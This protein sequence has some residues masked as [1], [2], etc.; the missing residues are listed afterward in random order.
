MMK[1]LYV[2]TVRGGCSTKIYA[3]TR[4]QRGKHEKEYVKDDS[5]NI[6]NFADADPVEAIKEATANGYA[7]VAA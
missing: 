7:V 2:E 3:F 1:V 4:K 6:R 5:G